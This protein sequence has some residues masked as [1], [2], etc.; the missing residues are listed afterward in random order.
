MNNIYVAC[1]FYNACNMRFYAVA[2]ALHVHMDI[3]SIGCECMP[4]ILNELNSEGC[5]LY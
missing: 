1:S 2:F 3:A 5:P 4:W